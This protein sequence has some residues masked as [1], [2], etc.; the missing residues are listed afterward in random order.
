M[1]EALE[2]L[3]A[4][5]AAA[6]ENAYA[7]YSGYAVGAALR[8]RD[9]RVFTGANVENASYPAGICAERAA[10]AAAVAAGAR[11]FDAIALYAAG[12]ATPCGICRQALAEFGD[13]EVVCA[14]PDA[15][16]RS[17]RL[18]DLLPEAF[19]L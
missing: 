10:L 9:G 19:S 13:M 11:Q 5:A 6:R 15:A 16:L 3:V 17:F 7:P 8:S 18:S 2:A 4:A 1:T 12:K 14:G